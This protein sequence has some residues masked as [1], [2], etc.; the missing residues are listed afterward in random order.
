V[1]EVKSR[2]EFVDSRTVVGEEAELICLFTSIAGPD[3]DPREAMRDVYSR[4]YE[5]LLL[6]CISSQLL[7]PSLR[8]NSRKF[9]RNRS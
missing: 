8:A 6:R 9:T 4:F 2:F 3:N 5:N 1:E 7:Y